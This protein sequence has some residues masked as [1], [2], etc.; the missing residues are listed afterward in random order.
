MFGIFAFYFF[1]FDDR[2]RQL[3]MWSELTARLKLLPSLPVCLFLFAPSSFPSSCLCSRS[4]PSWAATS[5]GRG[6][7][8]G[9]SSSAVCLKKQDEEKWLQGGAQLS[10]VWVNERDIWSITIWI[11]YY[12]ESIW[13][14]ISFMIVLL[15]TDYITPILNV[16]GT[17]CQ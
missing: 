5:P 16:Q 10:F 15:I 9:R 6:S 17:K 12:H 2:I 7:L 11:I 13:E 3:H 8:W 1:K 14:E 4:A